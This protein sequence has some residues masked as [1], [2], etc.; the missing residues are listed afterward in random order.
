M[1]ERYQSYNVES[2]E[3]TG[4][5]FWAPYPKP[6]EAPRAAAAGPH[7]VE[8]ATDAYQKRE[9]LDLR[10]NR[11]LRMLT[12]A[13]GPAY[14]RVSGSWA[15]S[16]YFQDDDRVA[17]PPPQGFQGVMTRAQW[18]G[19]VDF[20]EEVDAKILTSF[21]TSAGAKNPDGSWNPEG[22]R[23]L[24]DYTGKLGG[25]IDAVEL[26]NEPNV[27]RPG[28]AP[29]VFARDIAT[30]RRLVE[31]VSPT[32]QIVGPGST[33]EAGFKLFPVPTPEQA[34]TVRLLS[35]TP[36]PRFDVFSHHFYGA[37]SQRCKALGAERG[38]EVTT[39]PAEALSESWLSRA[40]QAQAHYRAL[41]DRFAPGAPIWITETA[42]TACGGD[43]WSAT[44]LDTFRYVD[45]L[46]RLARQN[47]SIIF[48]NTLAASDY[49][50]I[51]DRTWLPR[52]NYWAALLWRRL[53]GQVVLDAGSNRGDLHVY[54]HC[55]R[56]RAGG[57]ALV[58][59][60]LS[61]TA[62]ASLRVD[63]PSERY[64]LTSDVLES[65]SVKLNGHS[66]ALTGGDTLPALDSVDAGAG[67]LS[68]SPA[69]VTFL[70]VPDAGNPACSTRQSL[71]H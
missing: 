3:V 13:L 20:A 15:N 2:V 10:S 32:T 26:T 18:A 62:A 65:S 48:H 22:A 58:A 33:G 69:S 59:V 30:L 29:D 56:G 9:P 6:G 49:A 67:T 40:D 42:Q 7:G 61:R 68:L 44:F 16:I 34:S 19:V 50:L 39:S 35:G 51:D 11:R 23:R 24:F 52:P 37:V 71:E 8:F 70:A 27:A 46:G 64:T 55:L 25:K 4:G 21:A 54:A 57:V 43:P 45:Q 47:V 36:T 60:N 14:M 53:M 41:R 12:K 31:D 63:S 28:Y 5:N 17:M 1:D 66:L 38:N